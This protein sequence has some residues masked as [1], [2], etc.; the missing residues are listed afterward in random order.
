MAGKGD[1]YRPV[2]GSKF[3][4]NYDRIFRKSTVDAE[5]D[6]GEIYYQCPECGQRFVLRDTEKCRFGCPTCDWRDY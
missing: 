5:A 1:K 2:D 4:E 6:T 3:R